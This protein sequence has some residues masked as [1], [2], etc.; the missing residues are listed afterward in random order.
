MLMFVALMFCST[1]FAFAAEPQRMEPAGGWQVKVMCSDVSA[2]L[3]I[4]P[5]DIVTV[6]DEKY[7][8]LAVF[9]GPVW[10]RG[11]PLA[12]TKAEACSVADALDPASLIV[13][14]APGVVAMTYT[15]GKD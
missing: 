8:T 9:Q 13:R 14:D 2:V 5:P 10:R 7:D 1:W 4:D 3:A 11:T 15:L 12:G 6:T